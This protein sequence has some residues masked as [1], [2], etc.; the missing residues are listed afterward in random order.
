MHADY[1]EQRVREDFLNPFFTALGWDVA[2]EFQL[3]PLQQEVI[4]EK[5]VLMAEGNKSADYAFSL[6]PNYKRV[7]FFA[8]AKKPSRKLKNATDC[9]QTVRYGW[10]GNTPLAVLTDFEEWFLLDSRAKT[11]LDSATLRILQGRHYTD[12][13]DREKFGALWSLFGREAVAGGSIERYVENLESLPASAG[14]Q[15]RL[16]GVAATPVDVDFLRKLETWRG[17]LAQSFYMARPLLSAEALTEATQRALDRLV[18]VRFLED[19]LIETEDRVIKWQG[20]DAW[21][22]FRAAARQLDAKYNGVLWKKHPLLDDDTFNPSAD[23]WAGICFDV[24]GNQTDFLFNLIPIPI[25][26]SIYERFLGNVIEI[27]DAHVKVAPKPEV[28]KAGGVYYTP[29]YIVDYITQNTIAAQLEG[30]TPAQVAGMKFADIA[31]GSGS[32]L[33]GVYDL[34][35]RWHGAYYAT[36][37]REAKRD[38]CLEVAGGWALS[39]KQRR[40]ILEQNLWG[41]DIDGQAVEVSK[42]SLYLKLLEDESAGSARQFQLDFGQRVLP[43]LDKNIVCGNSLVDF[44]ISDS[45]QLT[46]EEEQKINPMDWKAAFPFLERS[47]FDAFVGN[48]PYVRIQTMKETMP[49]APP[50]YREHYK[51]AVKG[52]YDIYVAFVEKALQLL[53][54]MGQM[55]YILPHKFFN[56][57]YG[58][59]TRQLIADGK[60]LS[61]VVHFGDSQIFSNATT[62]VVK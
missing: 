22:N 59:A 60:H 32:F 3:D 54:N 23:V 40:A 49:A 41:A 18:F 44:D 24:S 12:W 57:Q 5:S 53:G 21:R 11:D 10:N 36:H 55:G 25:L 58:A 38:G 8:E 61:E 45:A 50:Y 29:E 62:V 15:R 33:L 37:P 14:K 56:A 28:R 39:L 6:A 35:L 31:C 16:F 43:D 9:F 48:P 42:L 7:R 26:G 4:I 13:L 30:K 19:K 27:E 52:N 1:K 46:P 51:T 34:L 20:G 2:H 47:G 17:E